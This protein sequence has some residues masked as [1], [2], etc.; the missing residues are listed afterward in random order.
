MSNHESTNDIQ[1]GT[2]AEGATFATRLQNVRDARKL[3]ESAVYG[4]DDVDE[5]FGDFQI[6]RPDV[7][8][9]ILM[10]NLPIDG[11][12]FDK[13]FWLEVALHMG[14]DW[15]STWRKVG[16]FMD[17]VDVFNIASKAD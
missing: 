12:S 1:V 14:P 6:K 17:R 7:F 2:A 8:A 3:I 13:R 5:L 9:S 15:I 11:M 4:E 16:A 10:N